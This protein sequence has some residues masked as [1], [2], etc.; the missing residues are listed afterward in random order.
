[1]KI[2]RMKA[3]FGTLQ[4][5]ELEL[6]EG[7]NIIEA[8]NEAGKSTWCAFLKA[9]LYG[10]DTMK[11]D[12]S[13]YISDKNRYRPWSGRAMEGT[14]E[15]T[16]GGREITMQRTAQGQAP[17][18]KLLAV[19]TGTFDKVEALQTGSAGETLT[20][21]TEPVFERTAFI[22][23]AGIRVENAADLEKCISGVVSGSESST[24]AKEV[25]DQLSAWQHK[26]R[27]NRTGTLPRLEAELETAEA[28]LRRLEEKNDELAE[29][30]AGLEKL[31]RDKLQLERDLEVH[32]KLEERDRKLRILD[33]RDRAKSAEDDLN[34]IQAE[35]SKSGR[36][37]TREDVAEIRGAISALGTLSASIQ[38]AEETRYHAQNALDSAVGQRG[39]SPFAG[40]SETAVA[41]KVAELRT[42]ETAAAAE[43]RKK[44]PVWLLAVLIAALV[45]GAA[46]A[47]LCSTVWH[48]LPAAVAGGVL[49]AA[50]LAALLY[51]PKDETDK[52]KYA[53]F[54]QERGL[55]DAEGFC[56]AAEAYLELCRAEEQA[57]IELAAAEQGVADARRNAEEKKDT[58][59]VLIGTFL[60]DVKDLHEVPD[61]VAHLEQL[62]ER[63]TK[64]EF[65][66]VSAQN[67]YATL[68]AGY[69]GDPEDVDRSYMPP[70]IRSKADTQ[71]ALTRVEERLRERTA[72]YDQARGELRAM[73]DPVV[74]AGERD[75]LR[76]AIAAQKAQYDTLTLALNVFR[77]AEAEMQTRVSPVIS[78]LAGGIA[79][80]LTDGKYRKLVFD[81]SFNAQA[82]TADEAVSRDVLAL[83]AGTSDQIYLA[84]RLAMCELVLGGEEPCPI[85][86]DD[87]LTN[88]DSTR[89]RGA[90]DLLREMAKD[91]QI[92]LFTC[93]SR[94]REYCA[95]F[96]DVHCIT[97]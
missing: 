61:A 12:S 82:G 9:M 85:V 22:R 57:K 8:D 77:E 44:K 48:V 86:L 43:K 72:L 18:R 5:A 32:E 55:A 59:L 65:T 1:M 35:L 24:S 66:M 13:G 73:G 91:R 37:V 7:L 41:D 34:S 69:T 93:H 23:Q 4:N 15:L 88:F 83:S 94:E 46:A 96:E 17:M 71:A 75:A 74:L 62:L 67:I 78:E 36:P 42:L 52:Q 90:L 6:R 26:L 60:P 45:L 70:P 64:A 56:K 25:G 84:L 10:I 38:R 21:V 68:I 76:E 33:A 87:A 31:E 80:R 79:R 40:L 19:Y 63:Q 27:Y 11:R 30:R 81:K 54:L 2:R 53:A 51:A 29:L 3:T 50:A 92:L 14:M 58:V 16:A 89:L 47:V 28:K 49:A 39:D 20:G 97:L 95:D